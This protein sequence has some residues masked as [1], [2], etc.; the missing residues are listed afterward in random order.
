MFVR[1]VSHGLSVL[2]TYA[3]LG[4]ATMSAPN[5]T[6]VSVNASFVVL[7]PPQDRRV[8]ANFVGMAECVMDPVPSVAVAE[9]LSMRYEIAYKN[10]QGQEIKADMFIEAQGFLSIDYDGE[11]TPILRINVY[12][13]RM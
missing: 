10:W 3:V 2:I 13:L 8:D 11:G 9:D 5:Q 12:F 7:E 1:A 6:H 4:L